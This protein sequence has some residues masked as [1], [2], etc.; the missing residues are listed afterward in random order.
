M[1]ERY[2]PLL[3]PCPFR[4]DLLT[5]RH[6]RRF[7]TLKARKLNKNK[8]FAGISDAI[9]KL[10]FGFSVSKHGLACYLIGYVHRQQVE[11]RRLSIKL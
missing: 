4:A 11:N 2:S 8:V 7:S 5:E 9:K 1:P 10:I 3:L 6:A